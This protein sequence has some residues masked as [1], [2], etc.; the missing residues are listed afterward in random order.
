MTSL[1]EIIYTVK[2]KQTVKLVSRV[3]GRT[4]IVRLKDKQLRFITQETC[5]QAFTS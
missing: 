2:R 4:L 3:I 1:N 5:K